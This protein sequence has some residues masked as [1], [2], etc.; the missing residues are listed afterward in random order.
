MVSYMGC[1]YVVSSQNMFPRGNGLCGRSYF[2]VCAKVPADFCHQVSIN[3]AT[4]ISLISSFLPTQAP[5]SRN[6][7]VYTHTTAQA[8]TAPPSFS[9]LS[10]SSF[11]AIPATF[12]VS[13]TYDFVDC[14]VTFYLSDVRSTDQ[15]D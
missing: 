6:I 3:P 14:L 7:D 10:R 12:G 15:P 9:S 4:V 13:I 2:G 1:S 11:T 5:P 8:H